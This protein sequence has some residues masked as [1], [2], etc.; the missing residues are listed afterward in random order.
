MTFLSTR[1]W[2]IFCFIGMLLLAGCGFH[3]R[4]GITLSNVIQPIYIDA[5]APNSPLVQLI[6][7][8]LKANDVALTSSSKV[9]KLV[10]HIS[11][12]QSNTELTSLR[13]GSEAGQYTVTTSVTISATGANGRTLIKPNTITQQR[14]YSSNATQTLSSGYMSNSIT[15]QMQQ[16]LAN[17]VL[18]QIAAI[19][20]TIKT[21]PTT[22][23]SPAS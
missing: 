3:L 6:E 15:S 21:T 19:N 23:H 16:S 1:S 10:L 2:S 5:A 14:T 11:K 8:Q 9:A 4:K 13:G 18:S 20:A 22:K 7:N 17:Q 12:I